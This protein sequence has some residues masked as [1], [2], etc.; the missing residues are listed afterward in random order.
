[1]QSILTVFSLVDRVLGMIKNIVAV[2]LSLV[3]AVLMVVVVVTRYVLGAPIF[4]LEEIILISVMWLYMIGASLACRE[5]S[6]LKADMVGLLVKNPR[7]LQAIQVLTTAISLVMAIYITQWA[8][9]LVSF[10]FRRV[11]TTPVFEI[12]WYFSQAAL[13]VGGIMFTIYLTRDLIVDIR[14]FFNTD[15]APK[16]DTAS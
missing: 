16:Q 3:V 12:P 4:G 14:A 15:S 11:Q 1:M 5:R 6:H 13:L 10:S 8:F 9:S 2:V 7:I